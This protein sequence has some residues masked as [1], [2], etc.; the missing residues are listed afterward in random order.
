MYFTQRSFHDS[1]IRILAA[2][3]CMRSR[4]PSHNLLTAISAENRHAWTLFNPPHLLWRADTIVY[5]VQ[6]LRPSV[7]SVYV[8]VFRPSIIPE[9][10]HGPSYV[11]KHD[12]SW[13]LVFTDKLCVTNK[14]ELTDNSC[15]RFY[16][17][18][19]ACIVY[20][21]SQIESAVLIMTW[22]LYLPGMKCYW[23]TDD[24]P[25]AVSPIPKEPTLRGM[26]RLLAVAAGIPT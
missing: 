10:I 16:L 1:R 18:A 14:E 3:T 23:S 26:I 12:Y 13:P 25:R 21:W 22:H 19:D 7:W 4:R 20:H 8:S 17:L 9:P 24:H 6:C 2:Q 15:R 5:T 11:K